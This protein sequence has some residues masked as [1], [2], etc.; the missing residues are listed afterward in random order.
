M[1]EPDFFDAP[2]AENL[3]P[4]PGRSQAS[5]LPR[6]SGRIKGKCGMCEQRKNRLAITHQAV[7]L[8]EGFIAT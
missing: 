2:H 1:S 7:F 8:D 6:P 3:L 5:Q 4:V